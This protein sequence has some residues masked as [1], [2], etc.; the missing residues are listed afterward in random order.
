MTG[1]VTHAGTEYAD[2]REGQFQ[3]TG[4]QRHAEERQAQKNPELP[5]LLGCYWKAQD[6]S[7]QLDGGVSPSFPSQLIAI[8][9]NIGIRVRAV[10]PLVAPSHAR[11]GASR[12]ALDLRAI[13]LAI[14]LAL[15][16]PLSAMVAAD[17]EL[18]HFTELC[19][20]E[21]RQT[22]HDRARAPIE[23]VVSENG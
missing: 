6:S 18:R 10:A 15:I 22:N 8:P 17:A 19:R 2:Q 1:T 9:G 3:R 21:M 7:E 23:V 5:G 13:G 20:L 14:P 12:L 16:C 4:S 11:L